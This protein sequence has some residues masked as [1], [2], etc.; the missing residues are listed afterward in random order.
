MTKE[1]VIWWVNHLFEIQKE[2]YFNKGMMKGVK[3][4]EEAQTMAI[5]ALSEDTKGY[6]TMSE[7]Y[8]KAIE[9][10][11]EPYKVIAEVKVDTDKII[12]RI[13]EEYVFIDEVV[14]CKDC[15]MYDPKYTDREYDCPIGLYAVYGN[16]FCSHAK[17]REP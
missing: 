13:K 8:D 5:E 4:V 6:S 14:R 16:D 12:K 11:F 7:E 9:A 17:R 3:E 10:L 15:K 1:E 2:E